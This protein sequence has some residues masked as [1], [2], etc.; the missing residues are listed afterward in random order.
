[1]IADKG[2]LTQIFKLKNSPKVEDRIK[3]IFN[4][5]SVMNYLGKGSPYMDK[6]FFSILEKWVNDPTTASK[7]KKEIFSFFLRKQDYTT[8]YS[9][10]R[11]LSV[12][13]KKEL[14]NQWKQTPR[15]QSSMEYLL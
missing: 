14:L 9:Y 7:L 1:M 11:Y 15:F 12:S 5:E 2:L 3:Y 10:W 4:G 13:E 6:D 8:I